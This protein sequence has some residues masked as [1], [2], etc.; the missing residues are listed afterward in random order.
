MKEIIRLNAIGGLTFSEKPVVIQDPKEK[1]SGILPILALVSLMVGIFWD[2]I[3]K[4][5]RNRFL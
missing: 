3:R 2:D 1:C 5:F 4:W